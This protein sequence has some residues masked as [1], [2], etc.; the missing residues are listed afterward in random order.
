MALV[1]TSK[2]MRQR[3]QDDLNATERDFHQWSEPKQIRL[4]LDGSEEEFRE[5]LDREM[6]RQKE[7]AAM[8]GI[9]DAR[10]EWFRVRDWHRSLGNEEQ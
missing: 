10:P 2:E 6:D 9:C 3:A 1:Q 7:F 8:Q 4:C 5:S